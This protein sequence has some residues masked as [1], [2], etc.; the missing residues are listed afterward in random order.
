ML[1][2]ILR[3]VTRIPLTLT[4]PT[5]VTTPEYYGSD[6][7]YINITTVEF[8]SRVPMREYVLTEPEREIAEK[9]VQEGVKLN[10]WSTL[11][12]RIT[13]NAPKL[14]EDLELIE[15]FLEKA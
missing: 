11:H 4:S 14:K 15:K 6:R 5:I 13:H 2:A 3:A 7:K 10:G 12:W 9:F 8:Y 1:L